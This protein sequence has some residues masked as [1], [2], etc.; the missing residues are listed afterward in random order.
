MRLFGGIVVRGVFPW[1]VW[2]SNLLEP[3]MCL[4]LQ[5]EYKVNVNL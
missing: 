1:K 3:I 5:I 2:K 4:I